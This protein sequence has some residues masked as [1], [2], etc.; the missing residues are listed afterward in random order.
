MPAARH[1][2]TS[3]ND[4]TPGDSPPPP[5]PT[6]TRQATRHRRHTHSQ[7]PH[8]RRPATATGAVLSPLLLVEVVAE[9]AAAHGVAQLGKGLRL[10]LA[11]PFTGHAEL[12][13]DL[14]QRAHLAVVEPET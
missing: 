3:A 2:T 6:T 13:A 4:H 7:R 11:D 8:A 5:P 14:L 10:D 12:F 9:P 1:V